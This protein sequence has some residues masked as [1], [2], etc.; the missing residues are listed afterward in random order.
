M[1]RVTLHSEGTPLCSFK[2]AASVPIRSL[3]AHFTPTQNG[4][5]DP[6]PSNVR[7]IVGRTG[8]S[9]TQCGKNLFNPSGVT[10]SSLPSV[11]YRYY[12]FSVPNGT[13]YIHNDSFTEGGANFY[14]VVV[15]DE[16]YKG[17]AD[18]R[19]GGSWMYHSTATQLIHT[20]V[21]V[22][23]TSSYIWFNVAGNVDNINEWL[24]KIVVS[25]EPI[26]EYISYDGIVTQV[27]FPSNGKNRIDTSTGWVSPQN[28]EENTGR[29]LTN[30]GARDN[31][32]TAVIP[33][34]TY[35]MS[36]TTYGY[37]MRVVFYRLNDAG[38]K[39][40]TRTLN[41]TSNSG[42]TF[43]VADDEHY[44]RV[45][46]KT[47]SYTDVP[48]GL[49]L[50]LGSTATTYEAYS[51]DNTFYGGYVDPVKGVIQSTWQF[52]DMTQL[53]Y[54][55]FNIGNSVTTISAF[56]G[57]IVSRNEMF[58]NIFKVAA[59]PNVSG[60]E[61]ID[62]N[63]GRLNICFS[64]SRGFTSLTDATDW[65]ESLKTGGV[66]PI[67]VAHIDAST[68]FPLDSA[69]LHSFEGQN[70]IWSF[71]NE[72]V[73]TD[74]D[75]F[76]T[77]MIQDA[78]KR[79][80]AYNQPH[81]ESKTG[82]IVSFTPYVRAP[83]KQLR[84]VF[85]PV[86]NLHG[87]D[88]SWPAGG[89]KNILDMAD[90]NIVLGK[91]IS[92]AG[93]ESTNANN[94]YNNKYISV[95]ASTAY[96]L[97]MSEKVSYC[98][99]MEYDS[100]K[101]FIKRTLFGDGTTAGKI[102]SAT[103]T[104]GS[105]TAYILIGSNMKG[106]T[107]SLADV[108]AVS[109]QVEEGSTATS[110]VP[111]ENV[112]PIDGWTEANVTKTGANIAESEYVLTNTS[113]YSAVLFIE[114][115]L[116]PSTTYTLSF[117]G[118]AGNLCYTNEKLFAYA[119]VSITGSR[120]SVTFTTKAEISRSTA[121]QYYSGRGWIILKNAQAQPADNTFTD[122]QLEVG[123]SATD[124]EPYSGEVY[125]VE[126]PVQGKNLFNEAKYADGTEVNNQGAY[127]YKYT[128]IIQLEANTQYRA[129]AF[130]K[131]SSAV[132]NID[133]IFIAVYSG[134]DTSISGA[135]VSNK[136][137]IFSGNIAT[138]SRT[139]FA[140]GVTGKIRVGFH[141][142]SGSSGTF[143]ENVVAAFQKWNFQIEK[144]STATAYEPYTNTVYGGYVDLITGEVWKV[145]D[146]F[147]LTTSNTTV[148]DRGAETT[149]ITRYYMR[150]EFGSIW[151]R[152][153]LNCICNR[154]K[155][156]STN[157]DFA[158]HYRWQL[159]GSSP[160][161]YWHTPECLTAEGAES[162]RASTD[163]IFCIKLATPVLVTTLTPTQLKAFK[164]QNNIW[165]DTNG[166]TTVKYWTH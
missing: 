133:N 43:T 132:T 3:K 139:L 86:Q 69:S 157:A 68:E 11:T 65:L 135:T 73:E 36:W 126:F 152:G 102:D 149:A 158:S 128:D 127:G 82:S 66:T 95:K 122:I 104:M 147:Q 41:S 153:S 121:A 78:K 31:K 23:V 38:N 62:W 142:T 97:S 89:G 33:G 81:L 75:L 42:F 72:K 155:L 150:T 116:K 39:V 9:I 30:G 8:L 27:T 113:M 141:Q 59:N 10:Y 91:Y 17:I 79:A 94:F 165:S 18:A 60:I 21:T 159:P 130:D 117:V 19:N 46:H 71:A 52:F 2:S 134:E 54:S 120:Q 112:C 61:A 160:V 154:L 63:T 4:S 129:S 103:V 12:A 162:I 1:E 88:Y 55:Q 100:S 115:D 137:F 123:S 125:N 35:T 93:A 56:P 98:S 67:I 118:T 166:N 45:S 80:L 22:T 106:S 37:D 70:Y 124:Y 57:T 92:N 110:W 20:D 47:G 140:T 109:W 83:I 58:C 111:Y 151:N 5:G 50:E 74:Y 87:Y 49:Q 25:K 144:G 136:Y 77:K 107:L 16:T 131:N 85:D 105:T 146:T 143:I 51:S 99:I 64:N 34:K 96:T 15:V 114:A 40:A 6:S 138:D 7:E 108:Q 14:A 29:V 26:S 101:T 156:S 13:Y 32:Y 28:Y 76:E 148:R 24:S 163:Y 44:I 53:T 161:I 84:C 164:D 145:W 48:A 90:E 119:N